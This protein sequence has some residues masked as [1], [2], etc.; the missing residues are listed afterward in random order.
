MLVTY[1]P[2]PYDGV[3]PARTCVEILENL[4]PAAMTP[5]LYAPRAT[6]GVSSTVS[7]TQTL[8]TPFRRFPYKLIRTL[9][10]LTVVEAYRRAIDAMDPR[11][12][13]AYFW[14][15]PP[16]SLILHAKEQGI[17]TVREM[18]NCDRGTAKRILDEAYS[19]HGAAISHSISDESVARER[20]QLHL[21]DYVLAPKQ[22]E[23]GL[24][25]AGVDPARII[26]ASFGWNPARFRPSG[27]PRQSSEL[28]VLFVGTVCIRKG[29][30]QLLQAWKRSGIE[31]KLVLVGRI[32]EEMRPFLSGYADDPSIQFIGFTKNL[33][34]LYRHADF[35]VFPTLE[36][37]SPQVII[38]AAGCG[39]PMVTT[40]MGGGRLIKDGVN[41]LIVPAGEVDALAAAMTTLAEA[42]EI[43]STFSRRAKL[44]A[45]TF[46]YQRIGATRANALI[47]LLRRDPRPARREMSEIDLSLLVES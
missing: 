4:P 9:G 25:D 12:S 38:E 23:P 15:D 32:A 37:G 39:L 24:I 43:R 46:T 36:E 5:R 19:T 40:P 6:V 44:A 1:C 10:T 33:A 11:T 30:I 35:F 31:G 2:I 26:P 7:V 41:G 3:G 47:G 22:T 16:K 8:P 18:I 20:E 17:V 34:D 27:E 13:L 29:A 45:E 14:P 42:P 21:Y 28:T